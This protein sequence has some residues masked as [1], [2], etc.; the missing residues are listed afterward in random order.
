ME[1]AKLQSPDAMPS[2]EAVVH[3]SNKLSV[4]MLAAG[5]R[6]ESR[7]RRPFFNI[8][9]VTVPGAPK[10]RV[11]F[12]GKMQAALERDSAN[13]RQRLLSPNISYRLQE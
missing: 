12:F 9:G 3:A 13:S 4:S 10:S 5:S 11:A 6:G 2:D 7:R 8:H 1:Q